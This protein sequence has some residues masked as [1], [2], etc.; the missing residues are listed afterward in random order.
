MQVTWSKDQT[1]KMWDIDRNIRSR[2]KEILLQNNCSSDR[3][4]ISMC[5]E[6]AE[7]GIG[8]LKE[9]DSKSGN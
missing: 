3:I 4:N 2:C 7:A 5:N 1:L 6:I 8:N 9:H